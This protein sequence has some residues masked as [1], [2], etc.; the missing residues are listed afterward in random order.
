[1]VK[2]FLGKESQHVDLSF[3][4]QI[5]TEFE[6]RENPVIRMDHSEHYKCYLD[7]DP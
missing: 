6:I 5:K 3:V 4:H 7:D 1:M 2:Q